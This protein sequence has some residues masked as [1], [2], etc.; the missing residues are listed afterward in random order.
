MEELVSFMPEKNVEVYYKEG[1]E[2]FEVNGCG[3]E[4]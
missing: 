2:N 3:Q 1:E 4:S